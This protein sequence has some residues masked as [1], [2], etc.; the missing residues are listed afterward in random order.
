MSLLRLG[1]LVAFVLGLGLS[2]TLSQT[3]HTLLSLLLLWRLR[4]PEVRRKA[5]WPLSQPVLAFS[6]VSLLSALSSEHVQAS[7]MASK[8]LLLAAALYVTFD[9][10]TESRAAERFLLG[11]VV[12]ATVAAAIGLVQVGLCPGPERDYGPPAWLYHRCFRARGLFSIYMTLAGVLTLVL[13][14]TFPKL[15]EGRASRGWL[16]PLW[17]VM[18]GGLLATHTRGAWVGFASGMLALLPSSRRM[19]WV[20]IGGLL[21]LVVGAVVGPHH[22]RQRLF[23]IA[24]PEDPTVRERI[25]M[26]RSSVAI[27]REYP[28]LGAGPGG[29]RREYQ[30][31]ALPEA[32]K[33]KIPHV[34][35]TPL[36]ILVERGVLGLVAWL[37]IWAEFYTR[38]VR[39]F[40]RLPLEA[41]RER[42]LVAGSLAAITGFLVAGLFEY[43]FG[44]SEVVMVA[45]SIVALAFIVERERNTRVG[46]GESTRPQGLDRR[47]ADC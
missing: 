7:L 33:R 36:Q 38:A 25:Y 13:L 2:I 27:W 17:L 6:V 10:L 11:L 16:T 45:W 15:I 31:Y 5:R 44:D 39:L 21:L 37:W 28:W 1:L 34:H 19:R 9:S 29:I 23:T 42:M 40:C 24:D 47:A 14:S 26:W 46:S 35:N 8:G 18:A 22:L 43:N 41:A 20:L 30:A 32:S 4:D 12:V 3:A